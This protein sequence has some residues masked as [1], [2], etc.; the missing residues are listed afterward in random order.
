MILKEHAFDMDDFFKDVEI[1]TEL[2]DWALTDK[3][4]SKHVKGGYSVIIQRG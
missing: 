2:Y 3:H 1:H 4:I